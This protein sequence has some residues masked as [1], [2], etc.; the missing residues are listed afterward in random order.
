MPMVTAA[1]TQPQSMSPWFLRDVGVSS[2][3][4]VSGNHSIAHIDSRKLHKIGSLPPPPPQHLAMNSLVQKEKMKIEKKMEDMKEDMKQGMRAA[5]TPPLVHMPRLARILLMKRLTFSTN[6][7]EDQR[8]LVLRKPRTM[9]GGKIPVEKTSARDVPTLSLLL[10]A[11][12]AD[13]T[14][15]CFECASDPIH[16]ALEWHG[17][18]AT[19]CSCAPLAAC[20]RND[21]SPNSW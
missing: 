19:S 2:S 14:L 13:N 4:S 10:L 12:C 7:K 20:D 8:Q 1:E 15:R 9:C 18:P 16:L 6:S 3:T 21:A 11:H 17:T 5:G